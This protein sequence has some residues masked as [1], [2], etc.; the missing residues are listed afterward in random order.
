MLPFFYLLYSIEGKKN[1]KI[2]ISSRI[3]K[4]KA[5]DIQ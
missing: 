3:N 4:I 2:K 1:K 5:E